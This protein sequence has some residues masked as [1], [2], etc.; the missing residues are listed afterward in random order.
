MKMPERDTLSPRDIGARISPSPRTKPHQRRKNVAHGARTCEKIESSVRR[1]PPHPAL[2]A[3]LS[4]KGERGI[5]HVSSPPPLGGEG[6]AQPALS[7]AGA[8]RVRG[9]ERS[10]A[11]SS[12][13]PSR[14]ITAHREHAE[15]RSGDRRSAIVKTALSPLPGLSGASALLS[16]HG[17]RRGPHSCARRLTGSRTR[18]D[19]F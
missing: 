15:P 8:G 19:L 5:T 7:S 4:P 3:T 6:G 18:S 13:L 1:G 11:I 12:H 17:C 10:T 14:G 2:R 9:S 16:P